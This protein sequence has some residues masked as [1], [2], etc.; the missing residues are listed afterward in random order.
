MRMA[1][2]VSSSCAKPMPNGNIVFLFDLATAVEDFFPAI[3]HHADIVPEIFA[4]VDR[5]G[6][7]GRGEAEIFFGF[8]IESALDRKIDGLAVFLFALRVDVLHVNDLILVEGRRPLE[9]EEIVAFLGGHLGSRARANPASPI[10]STVTSVLFFSPHCF[11]VSFV[12][13]LVESG[14]EVHPL[15]NF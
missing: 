13:P 9:E 8:R 4:P 3:G 7:K 14:D 6:H 10:L 5:V 12:E 1:M 11:D 2:A 15:E